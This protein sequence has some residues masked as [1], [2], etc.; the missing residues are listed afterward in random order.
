MLTLSKVLRIRGKADFWGAV[1]SSL[2]GLS[3]NYFHSRDHSN[4]VRLHP[5]V[6]DRY[7]TWLS[8]T[9]N[10][11]ST[12]IVTRQDVLHTT[13]VTTAS[14]VTITPTPIAKRDALDANEIIQGFRR[15][16]EALNVTVIDTPQM[17]ASFSSACDCQTYA[18]STVLT[19]HT[20]AAQV[21]P[22]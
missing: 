22:H 17:S 7:L 13:V 18:G 5:K 9:T 14:T 1:L 10:I 8:T 12:T 20:N 6:P 3:C 4:N 16:K 21:S 19:T 2:Y 11:F 15:E